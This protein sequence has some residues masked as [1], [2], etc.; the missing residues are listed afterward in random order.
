[1]PC[2]QIPNPAALVFPPTLIP[3]AER[4]S[5]YAG[6]ATLVDIGTIAPLTVITSA[7]HLEMKL[8]DTKK[9]LPQKY[10]K[11]DAKHNSWAAMSNRTTAPGKKFSRFSEDAKRHIYSDVSIK[12]TSAACHLI[13][14]DTW[15]LTIISNLRQR[16]LA[17][18]NIQVWAPHGKNKPPE[19]GTYGLA[20]KLLNVFLKHELCWHVA[21]R[22]VGYPQ[23]V[24]YAPSRS[25]DL[26]QY[27]CAL[28][29]PID[30]VVLK[31]LTA[32]PLGLGS[33]GKKLLKYNGDVK[34]SSDGNF[35]PWSQLNC[36]RTYYGLQL[37]L[38]RIA[39]NT[40]PVGC[41]C[42]GASGG[43]PAAAAKKLTQD[44]AGWFE[45]EFG[46]K[47]PR[48]NYPDWIEVACELTDEVIKK[49]FD[50][51]R[52]NATD[53]GSGGSAPAALRTNPPS[54]ESSGKDQPAAGSSGCLQCDLGKEILDEHRRRLGAIPA[55]LPPLRAGPIKCD[56]I[57]RIRCSSADGWAWQYH[58]SQQSV[59][60]DLFS[61]QGPQ[62]A[63]V[64]RY[65]TFCAARGYP[66]FPFGIIG[67]ESRSIRKSTRTGANAGHANFRN[68]AKEAV[69]IMQQIF[70]L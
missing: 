44:C 54:C 36:L 14:F 65:R 7:L 69:D 42:G 20:Q 70:A 52:W 48:N 16:G 50:T 5:K 22:W 30:R 60:V 31:A 27:L 67:N 39:M 1:M 2:C 64:N 8:W 61:E 53:S 32:L 15:L 47:H 18:A 4:F 13:D 29:A 40:W 19:L 9:S 43:T 23:F 41:A 26:P 63:A 28:H 3:D 17:N 68:I 58:V 34:Q 25:P 49:T 57:H 46:P 21:G 37:M 59:R 45:K 6:G 62:A 11:N 55:V 56:G 24:L 35:R 51:I 66:P 12:T 33:D 38:R 10:R